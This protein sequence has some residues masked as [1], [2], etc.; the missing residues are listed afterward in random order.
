MKKIIIL[1]VAIVAIGGIVYYATGSGLK[2]SIFSASNP[3]AQQQT[4]VKF[5]TFDGDNS[6][7]TKTVSLA[8]VTFDVKSSKGEMLNPC[9]V[10]TKYAFNGNKILVSGKE[11]SEVIFTPSGM[12]CPTA[13]TTKG[14]D[15]KVT[16]TPAPALPKVT[17]VVGLGY[18]DGKVMTRL[19]LANVNFSY[20]YKNTALKPCDTSAKYTFDGNKV[21]ANG[22]AVSEVIL[23]PTGVACP[24]NCSAL[25]Q[26]VINKTDASS[27]QDAIKQMKDA[28]CS[29]ELIQNTQCK[30]IENTF[31]NSLKSVPED[32]SDNDKMQS[33]TLAYQKMGDPQMGGPQMQCKFDNKY[34]DAYWCKADIQVLY[35][36]GIN[37]ESSYQDMIK[38][39]CVIPA[40]LQD[41]GQ[42]FDC[43]LLEKAMQEGL[44]AKDELVKADV[45][46]YKLKPTVQNC[47]LDNDK[48]QPYKSLKT[49]KCKSGNDVVW[50]LYKMIIDF[51]SN[52]VSNLKLKYEDLGSVGCEIT[53]DVKVGYK[54]GTETNCDNAIQNFSDFLSQY[55][56]SE[57]VKANNMLSVYVLDA[58]KRASKI[59]GCV[60][61]ADL[62][63]KYDSL[64]LV[65]FCE[66]WFNS[67]KKALDDGNQQDKAYYAYTSLMNTGSGK[68]V[69]SI[70]QD[71][72]AQYN[73]IVCGPT[74][75][76][77]ISHLGQLK[78]NP[79]NAMFKTLV[80]QDHFDV[81][82]KYCAALVSPEV[83]S[84][85]SEL[86]GQ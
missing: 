8:D 43:K 54:I 69:P 55:S 9:S 75:N 86:V 85:Y 18:F 10:G 67:V 31:Y 19:S 44:E 82:K 26:N 73:S 71:L 3:N 50:G 2:G 16:T 74:V 51:N 39:G 38:R 22:K 17:G 6:V 76:S 57:K 13:T 32:K 77:F 48:E 28:K 59:G 11:V 21:L 62:K 37:A 36:A 4:G 27:A 24:V 56:D 53:E 84:Q 58:Y 15:G 25:A 65:Y 83:E 79:S 45:T 42:K 12:S 7:G 68:C 35:K 29:E 46:Y 14:R 80:K 61:P 78:I 1:L 33:L 81:K 49:L 20:N 64:S 60:V 72:Q 30:Y 47:E 23:V 70:P 40:G 66:G 52:Q 5:K 63:E 34:K 41:M